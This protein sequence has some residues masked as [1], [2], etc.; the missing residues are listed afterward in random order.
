[1]S[2]A[3]PEEDVAMF[4]FRV[5][6]QEVN[7]LMSL[8]EPGKVVQGEKDLIETCQYVI[9]IRRNP[10]PEVEVFGHPWLITGLERVGVLKQLV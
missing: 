2:A 6:A 3:I 7:C 10:A 4:R 5:N 8:K 9:D 1:M